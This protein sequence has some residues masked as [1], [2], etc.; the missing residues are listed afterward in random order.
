MV[1]LIT[2]FPVALPWA[3]E[4]A[5]TILHMTHASQELGNALADVLFGDSTRAAASAQTWPRA[6]ESCRP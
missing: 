4:N 6:L 2:S 3:A 5:S 1:V